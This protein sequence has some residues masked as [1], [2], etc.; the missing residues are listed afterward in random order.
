MKTEWDFQKRFESMNLVDPQYEILILGNSLALDGLDAGYIT[1]N[2]APSYNMSIAGASV[3]TSQI[4][5][6]E[7][8]GDHEYKPSK[9]I[10]GQGSYIGMFD[11]TLVHPIVDYTLDGKRFGP[12]DLPFFKFKWLFKGLLKKGISKAHREAY[13]DAGQLKFSKTVEDNTELD[14]ENEFNYSIYADNQYIHEMIRLC[15]YYNIEFYCVEMTGY[16]YVRHSRKF[17]CMIMNNDLNNGYLYDL[18][19]IEIGN[20][21]DDKVDWVGNSHLNIIGA[22]KFT[23]LMMETIN[24]DKDCIPYLK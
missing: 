13:F 5:L 2:Y 10:L 3:R 7:Y 17:D 22:E 24:D 16:K 23:T 15:D 4:Q 11:T 1:K 19:T 20:L 9:V 6:E 12:R 21:F 14:N 8:L 18:N